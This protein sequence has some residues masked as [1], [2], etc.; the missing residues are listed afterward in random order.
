MPD[1]T[2]AER[3]EHGFFT[4]TIAQFANNFLYVRIEQIAP[5]I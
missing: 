2:K 1:G 3:T 4:I 5:A